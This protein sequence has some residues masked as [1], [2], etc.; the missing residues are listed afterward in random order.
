MI[1]L[2]QKKIKITNIL[3]IYVLYYY[4]EELSLTIYSAKLFDFLP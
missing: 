3:P 2:E 1:S 4:K